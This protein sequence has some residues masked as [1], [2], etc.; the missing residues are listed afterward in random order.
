MEIRCHLSEGVAS[1]DMLLG[2]LEKLL[3]NEDYFTREY[4]G[5]EDTLRGMLVLVSLLVA[6]CGVSACDSTKKYGSCVDLSEVIE[7]A[8][9]SVHC[10]VFEVCLCALAATQSACCMP[11]FQY[12]PTQFK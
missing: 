2:E 6:F 8:P 3:G 11:E 9:H 10:F 4:V 5:A 1:E 7:A 12:F